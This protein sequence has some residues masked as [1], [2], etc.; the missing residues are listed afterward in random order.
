MGSLSSKKPDR[1]LSE[2]DLDQSCL[3]AISS[4]VSSFNLCEHGTVM[5]EF[6][7]G[8]LH[9]KHSLFLSVLLTLQLGLVHRVSAHVPTYCMP[10][11]LVGDA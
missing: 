6:I 9:I 3:N 8:V 2:K 11:C 4:I 5:V 7:Q 10:R 1:E